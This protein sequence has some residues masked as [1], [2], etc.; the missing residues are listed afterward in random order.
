M[1]DDEDIVIRMTCLEAEVR[2]EEEGSAS[3]TWSGE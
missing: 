2:R 3:Q 1:S